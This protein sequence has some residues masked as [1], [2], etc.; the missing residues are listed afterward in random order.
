MS[1][2]NFLI[3]GVRDGIVSALQ[4]TLIFLLLSVVVVIFILWKIVE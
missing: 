3:S 2:C 1:E 4:R